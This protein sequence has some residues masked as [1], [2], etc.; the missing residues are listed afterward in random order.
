M[1]KP[2]YSLHDAML[3]LPGLIVSWIFWCHIGRC[4]HLWD[5]GIL[6]NTTIYEIPLDQQQQS[7]PCRR[8][9]HCIAFKICA[10]IHC[11]TIVIFSLIPPISHNLDAAIIPFTFFIYFPLKKKRAA[12]F[13]FFFPQEK[14][15]GGS[16][17]RDGRWGLDK[18]VHC[19][20]KN[21]PKNIITKYKKP[22]K[23]RHKI[24]PYIT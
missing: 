9:L 11:F 5:M 14:N 4:C 22:P 20:S 24:S 10:L 2:E 17:L 1:S 16:V 21:L 8:S 7:S 12:S 15:T 19:F 18:S 6:A 23:H 13:W 3:A